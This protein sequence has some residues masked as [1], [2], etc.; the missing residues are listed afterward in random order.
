MR[1][2]R[3]TMTAGAA[4]LFDVP[5]GGISLAGGLPDLSPIVMKELSEQVGRQIRLGGRTILQYSTMET[6][7]DLVEAIEDLAGRESMRPLASN[8]VPT[9]GSQLGLAAVCRALVAD[10]EYI[11]TEELTYPGARSAFAWC[12]AR[13][14][15]VPMD[16]EGLI[17]EALVETVTRVRASGGGLDVLYTVP[18]FHN[19]TGRTQSTDRR[20]RLLETCEA[21][22]VHVIED[23]PYG[24]L[25]FT[26]R[27]LPAL[28]SMSPAGVTYLGTFS[29]VFVPGLR[30]GWIDPA[31]QYHERIRDAVEA[32]TLS[33][34]PIAQAI[35]A[36]YHR[37]CGWD[38]AIARFREIYARKATVLSEALVASG[39]DRDRWS[40]REPDGGFYLW[41]TDVTGADTAGIAEMARRAGTALVPGAQFGDTRTAGA[42]LRLSFS[43]ASENE[44]RTAARRLCEVISGTTTVQEDAA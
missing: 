9:S 3:I 21:L 35:I 40:W 34:S 15:P 33:P 23:N 29:K 31:V 37:R 24:M 1:N 5:S 43:G 19:P 16:E 2:E 41:L 25:S 38:R 27:E 44:L 11:A 22:G 12:G 36:G 17:P 42:G 26:G 13:V 8:L 18:T 30:C 4:H 14:A 32:V 7:G 20:E 10:G 28:K 39:I 6:P